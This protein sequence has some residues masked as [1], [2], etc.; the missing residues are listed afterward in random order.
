MS[1]YD[2][3][4]E[5]YKKFRTQYLEKE[6]ETWRN[7]AKDAQR[8]KVMVIACSDSRVNPAII[9]HAGLGDIFTV[10][11]VANLVPP[12]KQ[13]HDTHHSTSAA[14][15]FAVKNL[16]VKHII[17]MGHSGCGGI[18]ALMADHDHTAELAPNEP[19][20][21]IRPWMQI[22]DNAADFTEEEK[23]R[24]DME[25]LATVC[26]KRACLISLNNLVTFPWVKQAI[27]DK[28]L[29]IHAWHFDIGSGILKEYNTET[30]QFE[31]LA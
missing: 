20:S 2:A 23:T 21:F 17:I 16:E 9:T 25:A 8:P 31:A 7:W 27:L 22:V 10:H 26:E 30:E 4:I 11:N 28:T 14:I 18:R 1:S 5:G 29:K 6:N 24:M 13:G 3:L 15:E 12:F 19:Y